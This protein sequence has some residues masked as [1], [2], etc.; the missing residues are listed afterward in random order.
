MQM[1]TTVRRTATV[2]ALALPF[3]L[4]ASGMAFAGESGGHGHGHG[5]DCDGAGPVATQDGGLLGLDG[6][7]NPGLNVGGVLGNGPTTQQVVQAD[8]ANSGI[9][10]SGGGCTNPGAESMVGYAGSAFQSR[11]LVD[12]ALDVSP[13]VNVGGIGGGPVSQSISQVDRSNSGILQ[14]GPGAGGF[15]SQQGGL[16]GLD[17]D[18]SPAI[19]IGGILSGSTQQSIAQ[20]DASNSG[21]VQG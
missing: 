2:G 1:R 11:D 9:V 6:G 21:I 15:A 16:L 17:L 14:D 19:N 7:V 10:Q 4:A 20:A 8:Q 3:A 18:V 13:G 12:A 5:H